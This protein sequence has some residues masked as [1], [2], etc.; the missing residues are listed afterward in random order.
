MPEVK[1]AYRAVGAHR[2]EHV[3][4]STC[5]AE[6]NVVD[7]FVVGDQLRFDVSGHLSPTK[8]LSSL[9]HKH[10]SIIKTSSGP[11]R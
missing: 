10:Q 3:A 9:K 8:D 11:N 7:F 1:H 2:G 6:C 4:A 5:S